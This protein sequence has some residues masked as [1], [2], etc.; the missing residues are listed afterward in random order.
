MRL[1][2]QIIRFRAQFLDYAIKTF[3]LDNAGK[4][5]SQA[6]NDYCMSTIITFE[7][8]VAHV[9]TQNDLAES[10]IKRL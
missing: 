9:H 1:L 6:F 5:I 3:R 8:P 7:Q 4:F 10:F 2:A